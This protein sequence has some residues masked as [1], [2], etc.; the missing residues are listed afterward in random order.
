MAETRQTDAEHDVEQVANILFVML[1]A[2]PDLSI[3]DV[4]RRN[5]QQGWTY[6]VRYDS[7]HD[8]AGD[9]RPQVQGRQLPPAELDQAWAKARRMHAANEFSWM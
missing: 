4:R 8:P 7:H 9:A 2:N 5:E 6:T 1:R 3:H